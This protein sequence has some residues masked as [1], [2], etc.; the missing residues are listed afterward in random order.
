MASSKKKIEEPAEEGEAWL[1]SYADMM[2]LIACLFILMMAFANYDPAGFQEK[3]EQI[4]KHFNEDK[5]K[6]S[7]QKMKHL[8]QEMV[9]HP[10]LK[11]MLK[12]SLHNGELIINF[13][14]SVL[15]GPGQS[16][17]LPEVVPVI[18]SMIDIVKTYNPNYKIV[19][20]G[21]TDNE[22]VHG[23]GAFSSNWALSGARAASV[24]ERFEYFGFNPKDLKA[25]GL[26]ASSPIAPNEDENGKPLIENQKLNRRVLIR[27]IEP[28]DSK[29]SVKLGLGAYFDDVSAGK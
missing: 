28:I 16:Q 27:V 14:G 1:V 21:H 12:V 5:Y 4:A 26:G 10:E 9:Q 17:L 24:V 13:S 25:L 19:V 2:T 3:T 23:K 20:E 7:E 15:F 18:D 29:R 8:E 11:K 6:N 22:P